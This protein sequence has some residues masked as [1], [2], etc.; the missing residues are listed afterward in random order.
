MAL[1][2]FDSPLVAAVAGFALLFPTAPS[3][4]AAPDPTVTA[5]APDAAVTRRLCAPPARPDRFSCHAMAL[6]PASGAARS[7]APKVQG[8]GPAQLRSAYQLPDR[9]RARGT[10][11]AVVVAYDLPTVEQDLKVYRAHFNL[12]ACTSANGCFTKLDQRGGRRYPPPDP[13]WGAEA[14]LDTQMVSASC[15]D[16]RILLVEADEPSHEDLGQAIDTAVKAGADIVSNSWGGVEQGTYQK[17]WERRHLDRPGIPITFSTGDS[18]FGSVFP[19]SSRYVTAVGGTR[20]AAGAN[21]RWVETAWELAG[22]GCSGYSVKPSWQRDDGCSRRSMADVSAVADPATGVAVYLSYQSNGWAVF[23]GTSAA[24]PLIA[25]VYGLAHR[26]RSSGYPSRYPYT[27]PGA[28]NDIRAGGGKG[29]RPLYLC[30]ARPGYDGP[31]GLGS[32]RGLAAFTPPGTV[33]EGADRPTKN[34]QRQLLTLPPIDPGPTMDRRNKRAG[35]G[36]LPPA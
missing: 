15:P 16:C 20:L 28:L 19:A 25:G 18:G 2:G 30:R 11:V 23:G 9:A 3:G 32:P 6:V 35:N 21:G 13:D 31:T 27:V 24:A 29:C 1:L 8:H 14:A 22:S 33:A 7:N 12:P 36:P 34:V 17:E 10:T 5:A 26:G 4:P